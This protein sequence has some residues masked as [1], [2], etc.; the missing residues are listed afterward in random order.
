MTK[1]TET[2]QPSV[3]DHGEDVVTVISFN[4][5][6]DGGPDTP[7]GGFPQRWLD[8][9][10]FLAPHRPDIVLRQEATHSHLDGNWRLRAA[11]SILG[12][13]P[14]GAMTGILTP[15]GTGRHPTAM[16]LRRS[17]FPS[18]EV[19]YDSPAQ[20]AQWRTPP[21]VVITRLAEVPEVDLQVASWHAAFNSSLGRHREADELTGF[22]D[23]VKGGKAFLGGGDCNEE[24]RQGSEE[25]PAVDWSSPD[26]T[27]PVHMAHRTMEL[28]D[29][30]RVNS[31]YL[32]RTL[33]ACGL[34]DVA[35]HAHSSLGQ[36]G[37]MAPTAGHAPEAAGQGGP[38][39]IDRIYADA[40]LIQAVI[41]VTVLDTNGLSDH[42]AV[43]VV[44]SRR[45]FAEGLR[46][47]YR[48]LASERAPAH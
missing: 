43:K 38:Q 12:R 16:F 20:R 6:E 33:L 28:P 45:R 2:Q 40:W 19:I 26:V 39:R 32:D 46:R 1:R 11:E 48:A 5:K 22:V 35:R 15:N 13:P 29:G 9:H 25:F 47:Q 37:A 23:K 36:D 24:P 21:T 30:T 44:F 10:E 7:D 18:H 17:T 3:V 8:A 31:P 42:H 14:Y 41:A 4:L 27:D 34:H